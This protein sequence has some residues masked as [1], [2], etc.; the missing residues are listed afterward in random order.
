MAFHSISDHALN[1][2]EQINQTFTY[3]VALAAARE[4]L[5]RHPEAGGF[6]LAPGAH[7]AQ[8]LD[9]MSEVDGLVG[10]ETFAAVSPTNNRKL[11]GDLQKLAD[12]PELHRYV[13]FASPRFPGT[14]RLPQFERDGIEVWSVEI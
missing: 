3:A 6:V 13:F 2:I 8:P 10:A 9:I 12:R 7:M 5:A 14:V 11:A 4:L 1:V